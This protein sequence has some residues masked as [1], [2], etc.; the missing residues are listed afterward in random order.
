MSLGAPAAPFL[1]SSTRATASEVVLYIFQ[2][3][4]IS[5]R[6]CSRDRHQIPPS[7]LAQVSVD[8]R[9]L[10]ALEELERGA[11]AGRDVGDLVGEAVLL[12]GRDRVAAADDGDRAVRGGVGQRLRDRERALGRDR[13]SRRRPSG[14]SRRRSSRP[15]RSR[16]NFARV[17]SPMSTPMSFGPI[18]SQATVFSVPTLR[19]SK[20]KA[21]VTTVSTGS[22]QLAAGLGEQ[23]L[24][25]LDAVVLDQRAADLLA[26]RLVEG[27]GHA[28][29]DD[30]AC[31]PWAAA[32]R[33]RRSCR[34]PS[35][36]R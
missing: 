34:R 2:L 10:L 5:L 36:R 22:T 25:H 28:A 14:R 15:S 20:S 26:L 27:E 17:A 30:A 3:P 35:P 16:A 19:A 23:R 4:A 12:D 24:R 32:P 29:A 9:Q 13:R 11:A 31:R 18:W 6:I 7:L 21:S 1:I 8:A 33:S